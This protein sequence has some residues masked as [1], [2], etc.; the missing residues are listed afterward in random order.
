MSSQIHINRK[1]MVVPGAGGGKNQEFLF[2]K[3]RV[4]VLQD[5]DSSSDG[6]WC[7]LHHDMNVF[8]TID[9]SI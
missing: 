8:H 7:W 6:Q 4:S 3:D 1:N 5:A 9:L 2:H